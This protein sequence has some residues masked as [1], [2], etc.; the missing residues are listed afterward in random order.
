MRSFY[1]LGWS[2]I[3]GKPVATV[4][5]D[6]NEPFYGIAQRM[7]EDGVSIDGLPY[8]ILGVENYAMPVIL[9]G[10][11]IGLMVEVPPQS[12]DPAQP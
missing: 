5:L 8:K 6:R 10:S 1:S 7:N 4:K 3:R 9:A 12:S 2:E 11:T